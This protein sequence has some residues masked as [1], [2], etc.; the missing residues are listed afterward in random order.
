MVFATQPVVYSGWYVFFEGG[1]ESL[2]WAINACF[3]IFV[4]LIVAIGEIS[5]RRSLNTEI[6]FVRP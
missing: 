5:Y 6:P 1:N 3:F 2:M 4:V